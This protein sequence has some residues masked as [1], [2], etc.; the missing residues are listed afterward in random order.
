MKHTIEEL[1]EFADE[2]TDGFVDIWQIAKQHRTDRELWGATIG[3]S[4]EPHYGATPDEAVRKALDTHDRQGN[5][6]NNPIGPLETGDLKPAGVV[7]S[8]ETVGGSTPQFIVSEK[9]AEKLRAAGLWH[10]VDEGDR[11]HEPG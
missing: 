11:S 7:V 3:E 5:P 4:S 8:F 6:D 9:I 2:H 10:G 1:G